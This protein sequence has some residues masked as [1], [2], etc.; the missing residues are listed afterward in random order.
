MPFWGE[1]FPGVL[2]TVGQCLGIPDNYSAL[3][4]LEVSDSQQ[5]KDR[6]VHCP[7]CPFQE[8]TDCFLEHDIELEKYC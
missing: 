6:R 3:L 7:L 4:H 1:S 5:R 2:N 8:R